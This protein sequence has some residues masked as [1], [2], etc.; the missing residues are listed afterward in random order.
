LGGARPAQAARTARAGGAEHASTRRAGRGWAARTDLQDLSNWDSVLTALTAGGITGSGK[1]RYDAVYRLLSATGREHPGP[2]L[3]GTSVTE[4]PLWGIPHGNDLQ[5]LQSYREELSYDAVGNILEMRHLRGTSNNASWSRRYDYF[6]ENNRLR[7]TSAPGDAIGTYSDPYGYLDNATND[8]GAHGSMTSMPHLAA[9]EWDYTDRLKHTLKS[10]GSAQDTYF[11]Y[12]ASGQRV[13]KVYVHDGLIEERIYLGSYEV[14]RRHTSG[15]ITT[16]P[17]EERQTLH[18][19]DDQRR[20]AMAETK[21]RDAGAAVSPAVT[22]WRFQLDN[23]LGSATLE[24]DAAGNVI[25]YEEYHPYGSTAFHTADG[26]YG[27]SAKRYRYTGKE[28]DEETSLYYHGAR[29]YAPWLG[30]WTAADPAGMMDGLNLYRY[31]RD[32]P[33][34]FSDPSGTQSS[35]AGANDL[36]DLGTYVDNG[37]TVHQYSTFAGD[38][39]FEEVEGSSSV[40]EAKAKASLPSKAKPVKKSAPEP[41]SEPAEV[42][43]EELAAAD[44]PELGVGE[45]VVKAIKESDTAQFVIGLGFGGLVGATPGGFLVP[46][47]SELSGVSNNFSPALRAG[48]GLGEAAWGIAQIIGGIGGAAGGGALAVGGAAA[49]ATGPG[50]LLGVPAMAG[51]AAAVG[52]SAAA[53]AEGGADVATGLGVF[54]SAL[55]S[56]GNGAGTSAPKSNYRE[57][58]FAEHPELRGKVVVHH[59]IEQQVLKRY[60]GLFT[61]SEIHALENLRGIPKSSNAR[62]HLSEIRRAW[63]EFY[64]SNASPTRQQI[65]DFAAELDKT[66]GSGFIPPR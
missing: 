33:I 66:L 15:S 42:D 24:L 57:T 50:A 26:N 17:T 29:Y 45:Q 2:Q 12:D 11:T 35:D 22:R 18:A 32:N 31:S 1:Y 60:P 58:F 28:K 8:A 65:I 20:V 48:M 47:G 38:F 52:A 34:L 27:V 5:A 19:M 9:M 54:M 25:S 6:L 41:Q 43:E 30:R 16:T 55:G 46:A 3:G 7:A 40:P 14:Y 63:N 49:T 61:E 13:R 59:A 56:P 23:H 10:N 62:L 4:P 39:V 36:V 37:Q 53:I 51:G 44:E 21:T 64:R